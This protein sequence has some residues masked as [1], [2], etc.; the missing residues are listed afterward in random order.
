MLKFKKKTMLINT[1]FNRHDKKNS[2]F[3]Y[4]LLSYDIIIIAFAIYLGVTITTLTGPTT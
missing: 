3:L 2:L 1:S 4:Y